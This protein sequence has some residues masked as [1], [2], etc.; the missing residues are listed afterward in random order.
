[1]MLSGTTVAILQGY[2]DRATEAKRHSKNANQGL[3]GMCSLILT[4]FIDV[5]TYQNG[6]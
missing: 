6:T 1:M 5:T 3:I 4:Q 2:E